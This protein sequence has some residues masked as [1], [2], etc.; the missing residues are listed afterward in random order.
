MLNLLLEK[1]LEGQKTGLT[2][3][4]LARRNGKTPGLVNRWLGAPSN[5]TLDTISDS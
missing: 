5:L 4:A 1:F 2:K 3:A